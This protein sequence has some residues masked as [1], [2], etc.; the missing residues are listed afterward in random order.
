[1]NSETLLRLSL[2]LFLLVKIAET[3]NFVDDLEKYMLTRQ[4]IANIQ[5]QV[6]PSKQ[7][8]YLSK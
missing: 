7:I 6:I 8:K 2:F 3:A 5:I 4:V 1:M